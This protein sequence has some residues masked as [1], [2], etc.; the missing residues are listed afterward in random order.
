MRY[1]NN[2]I[3]GSN[4]TG[5]GT[6]AYPF[7]GTVGGYPVANVTLGITSEMLENSS[8]YNEDNAYPG[9]PDEVLMADYESPNVVGSEFNDFYTLYGMVTMAPPFPPELSEANKTAYE[10]AGLRL[11]IK[12]P[13]T[14]CTDGT[15]YHNQSYIQQ[16]CFPATKLFSIRWYLGRRLRRK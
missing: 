5:V 7:N 15:Y 10:Q 14:V 2:V 3:P 13:S 12:S 11:P 16:G 8:W 9:W 1:L 6:K 4:N